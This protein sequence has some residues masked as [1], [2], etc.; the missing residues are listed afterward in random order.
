MF[1]IDP[2]Y[3]EIKTT[4][5]KGRGAF[6]RTRIEAGTVIGDYLGTII[7]PDPID[8]HDDE[9]H[10]GL[11]YAMIT[12]KQ[13][14]L[15]DR[16]SIGIHIIN[17][18][19]EPNIAFTPYKGHILYVALRTIFPHE[20]LTVN[21]LIDPEH[22]E[23]NYY[24]CHCHAP[25]CKGTWY[26]HPNKLKMFDALFD[27]S[28]AGQSEE[29]RALPYGRPLP[30]LSH[31]PP[32]FDDNEFYDLFGSMILKPTTYPDTTF[33]SLSEIRSRIRTNGTTLTFP[34]IG[35]NVRGVMDTLVITEN[36]Q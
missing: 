26:I 13:A 18:S 16:E 8:D 12:N 3:Y 19:C 23:R 14:I 35:L 34:A 1:L 2:S 21:Y 15:P 22:G 31:Y 7:D 11:Y 5:D 24:I 30:K 25:T 9:Y 4:H 17:H 10:D 6:A 29:E 27:E 33:P 28:A 20:E 36:I 32:H